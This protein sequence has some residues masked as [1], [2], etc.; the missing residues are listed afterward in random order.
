[1]KATTLISLALGASAGF[2]AA[3]NNFQ[4]DLDQ[5]C[6]ERQC[7]TSNDCCGGWSCNGS[8]C[9]L[10]PSDGGLGGSDGGGCPTACAAP[11]PVCNPD[12][13]SCVSCT[14]TSCGAGKVCD[15]TVG[16]VGCA[17]QS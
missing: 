2:L 15:P 7:S 3:C 4:A 13:K 12:S 14:A 6:S 5:Y 9:Q 16:C 10:P 1:M 8:R 17:K 11:T